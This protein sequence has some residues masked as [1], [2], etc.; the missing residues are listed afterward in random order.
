MLG[1]TEGR[2]LVF[3]NVTSGTQT[4]RNA[5]GNWRYVLARKERKSEKERSERTE[6][7]RV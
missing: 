2:T 6:A 4:N 7:S 1:R 3:R 5:D